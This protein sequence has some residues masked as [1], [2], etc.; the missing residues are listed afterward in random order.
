MYDV[1][2]MKKKNDS[3]LNNQPQQIVKCLR[4]NFYN[5]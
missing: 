2:F 3:E 1:G 4:V 5:W